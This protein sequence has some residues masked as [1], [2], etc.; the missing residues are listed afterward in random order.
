MELKPVSIALDEYPVAI[1]TL[2]KKAKVFDSSCSPEA[3]VLYIEKGDGYFLKQAAA[4]AL[5]C[6]Y[7]MTQYFLI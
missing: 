6:E 2:L 7:Q 1:R 5:M 3:R 4:S